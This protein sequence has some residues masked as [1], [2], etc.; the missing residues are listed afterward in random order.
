MP[1]DRTIGNYH[2]S[3]NARIRKVGRLIGPAAY[4]VGGETITA[5]AAGMAKIEAALVSHATDAGATAVYLIVA[6]PAT[7]TVRWYNLA[8]GAEAIAGT[9]L[10]GFSARFELIG[11]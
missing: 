10:S 4:V 9:D 2:D 5:A 8:T 3:S 7:M 1:I 11:Y 6:N